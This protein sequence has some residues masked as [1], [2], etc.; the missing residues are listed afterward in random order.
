[1]N[2]VA[3]LM[4]PLDTSL[5]APGAIPAPLPRNPTPEEIAARQA[6]ID[7]NPIA[8]AIKNSLAL[9][10]GVPTSSLTITDIRIVDGGLVVEAGRRQLREDLIQL[11][12][13][14]QLQG[15]GLMNGSCGNDCDTVEVDFIITLSPADADAAQSK[16]TPMVNFTM[17]DI[18]I[19]PGSTIAGIPIQIFGSDIVLSPLREYAYFSTGTCPVGYTCSNTC[20]DAGLV[21]DDIW[22]C[23]ENGV[24]VLLEAC[25]A[26]GLGPAPETNQTCCRAPEPDTC[27]ATAQQLMP[28]PP[29]P[30][31][32]EPETEPAPEP[33]PFPEPEPEPYPE[34]EPAP[35]P[36]PSPEPE[37]E[38][39]P[40]PIETDWWPF[41]EQMTY[42]IVGGGG[43]ISL[44]FTLVCCKKI[45]NKCTGKGGGA[46]ARRGKHPYGVKLA[47]VKHEEMWKQMVQASSK[48]ERKARGKGV[49]KLKGVRSPMKELQIERLRESLDG[50]G[51]RRDRAPM[52]EVSQVSDRYEVPAPPLDLDP[53]VTP[54]L[55]DTY[56]QGASSATGS[57]GRDAGREGKRLEP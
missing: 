11:A 23:T 16:T 20:G 19:P 56:A 33:E 44:V 14:R 47:A 10:L 36:E 22:T 17:P 4:I 26:N 50:G 9:G 30:E 12:E 35:E 41:D 15:S 32:P 49:H 8:N 24:A 40:E 57:G 52:G 29:E 34:P 38:P 21:A 7:A 18:Y 39:I 37:P 45:Y 28:P 46:A 53:P 13:R 2:L 51:G 31:P 5:L 1:V 48:K 25:A 3:S 42:V 27:Y 55:E 54:P 6:E 43:S